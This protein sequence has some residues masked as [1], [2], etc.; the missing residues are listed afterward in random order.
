MKENLEYRVGALLYIPALNKTAADKIIWH[1]FDRLTSCCF[2]LEDSIQDNALELAEDMLLETLTK[3]QNGMDEEELPNIFIRVRN[4]EHL[5]HIHRKFESVHNVIT[6][7]N[8]PKFDLGNA[9]DY[10]SV[11]CHNI[12]NSKAKKTFY[13]MPI[14]ESR[15]IADICTRTGTLHKLKEIID[16]INKYV[17]NIRLGGNDFSNLYGV[18]RNVSQTIYDIGVIRDII[19]DIINVFSFDYVVSGPVWEYFKRNDYDDA[20]KIGLK[21]ECELDRVNCII[22]KTAIHPSQLPIIYDSL[23]VTKEDYDDACK[24]LNWQ[25]ADFAVEKGTSARMNEVKCHRKWAKKIK[26]LGDIYG[27]KSELEA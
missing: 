15:M 12:N 10:V 5:Y 2:C 14:L 16:T 8:L 20:W 18:R 25:N 3:I 26:A 17:L 11:I 24:I 4:P 6:G 1:K 22:G 21:R 23:M 13:V 9:E 19:T 27:V 7:Y